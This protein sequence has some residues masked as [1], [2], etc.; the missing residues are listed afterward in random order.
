M[1]YKGRVSLF[2]YLSVLNDRIII[3]RILI[4][5]LFLFLFKGWLEIEIWDLNA[6]ESRNLMLLKNN[7]ASFTILVYDGLYVGVDNVCRVT[8][9]FLDQSQELS[10]S[11]CNW[12]QVHGG[13]KGE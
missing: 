8:F 4:I 7:F 6:D 5:V 2:T 10:T 12:Q 1:I 11:S 3:N 9:D 13:S